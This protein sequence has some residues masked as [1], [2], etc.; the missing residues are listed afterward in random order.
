M[1]GLEFILLLFEQYFNK[2]CLCW[3]RTHPCVLRRASR[4]KSVGIKSAI[5]GLTISK[6]DVQEMKA[7]FA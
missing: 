6:T 3:E 7:I 5:L 2:K 4:R 1:S